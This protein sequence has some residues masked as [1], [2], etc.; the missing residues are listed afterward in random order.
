MI[1]S[2][3]YVVKLEQG[4]SINVKS[5]N[6]G[7]TGNTYSIHT[8]IFLGDYADSTDIDLNGT[9]IRL[10]GAFVYNQTAVN[11]IDVTSS[12]HG[13]LLIGSKTKRQLFN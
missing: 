9:S 2:E 8:I 6:A 10:P 13:I 12:P 11:T 4:E 1:Q 5:L 7:D 3:K